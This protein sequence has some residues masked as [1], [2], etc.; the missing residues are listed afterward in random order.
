MAAARYAQFEKYGDTAPVDVGRR[1]DRYLEYFL[2]ILY[3]T[4]FFLRQCGFSARHD[5][6]PGLRP[7]FSTILRKTAYNSAIVLAIPHDI[8]VTERG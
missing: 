8:S 7:N 4:A 5:V 3:L 2:R 6:V 1:R